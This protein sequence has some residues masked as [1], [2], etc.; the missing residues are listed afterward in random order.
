MLQL[1][2]LNS[3]HSLLDIGE[4]DTDMDRLVH[5]SPPELVGVLRSLLVFVCLI[6]FSVETFGFHKKLLVILQSKNKP[7]NGVFTF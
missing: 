2:L 1:Q 6:T 7:F 5:D 3:F 4:R